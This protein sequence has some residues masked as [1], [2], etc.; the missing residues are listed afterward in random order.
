MSH[1]I[2]SALMAPNDARALQQ[3]LAGLWTGRMHTGLNT[4]HFH[5]GFTSVVG[6]VGRQGH[7]RACYSCRACKTHIRSRHSHLTSSHS[8]SGLTSGQ[9]ELYLMLQRVCALLRVPARKGEQCKFHHHYMNCL[10]KSA[11]HSG[12]TAFQLHMASNR[13]SHPTHIPIPK[14]CFFNLSVPILLT[15]P[16]PP[17][18]KASIINTDSRNK[19]SPDL[20]VWLQPT[21]CTRACVVCKLSQRASCRV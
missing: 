18:L 17:T 16:P 2:P 1:N 20:V 15:S 10:G 4:C 13:N 6:L 21:P 3:R 19:I 7:K 11:C 14:T 5:S 12:G 8:S 9:L